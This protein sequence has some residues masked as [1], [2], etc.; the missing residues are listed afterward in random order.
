MECHTL[1]QASTYRLGG[2]GVGWR[3]GHEGGEAMSS[4]HWLAVAAYDDTQDSVECD[5]GWWS[6]D[7]PLACAGGGGDMLVRL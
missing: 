1:L 2:V 7:V 3:R 5:H 4:S 6:Y